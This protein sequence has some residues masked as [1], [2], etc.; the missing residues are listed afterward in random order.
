MKKGLVLIANGF[1][2]TEG[3]ATID[4]LKRAGIS[5]DIVSMMDT[6]N[7][8][9]QSGLQ[10][11]LEKNVKEIDTDDY[12]FL[13]IP[14][15][16]AVFNILSKLD[17]VNRII[18]DFSKTNRLIATICAAPMLV[19]KL[20][21]F[22]NRKFT[23]FPGC[24]AGILGKYTGNPVQ[25]SDN[26]ITGKSMGHSIEFGLELIKCLLGNGVYNQI[27]QSIL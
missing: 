13:F 6:N 7:I 5:L 8:T 17:I 20:G 24:E 10:L 2:D 11:T 14:G 16:K 19:G 9:T 15:G 12:D 26:F 25:I 23:C 18:L 3:I 21:L 1:E 22:E 27:K 4:L